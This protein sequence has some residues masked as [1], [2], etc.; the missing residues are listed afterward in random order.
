MAVH[1]CATN[2]PDTGYAGAACT[3][4]ISAGKARQGK[5][6]QCACGE[7]LV[8]WHDFVAQKVGRFG[9]VKVCLGLTPP[10]AVSAKLAPA[11]LCMSRV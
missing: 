4:L 8:E 6:Y 1:C 7:K 2:K 10:Q 9:A 3:A 5:A 11:R